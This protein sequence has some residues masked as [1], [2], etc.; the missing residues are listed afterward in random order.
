[1]GFIGDCLQNIRLCRNSIVSLENE[2]IP[3]PAVF[4]PLGHSPSIGTITFFPQPLALS[5]YRILLAQ[6]SPLLPPYHPTIRK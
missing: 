1:M 4:A 6:P 5:Y 3:D 2:N